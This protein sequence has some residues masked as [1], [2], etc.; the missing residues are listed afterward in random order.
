MQMVNIYFKQKKQEETRS[1]ASCQNVRELRMWGIP[2]CSVASCRQETSLT[3]CCRMR[4]TRK[5]YQFVRC[6]AQRLQSIT[7]RHHRTYVRQICVPDMYLGRYGPARSRF[8]ELD[9]VWSHVRVSHGSSL[10]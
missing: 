7:F 3:Y 1:W 6:D 10:T 4:T 8:K 9:P 5:P 2:N